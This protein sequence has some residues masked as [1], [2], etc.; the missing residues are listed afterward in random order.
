MQ[1]RNRR[2]YHLFLRHHIFEA[3]LS[4]E[5]RSK[6][7]VQITD[8]AYAVDVMPINKV[9]SLQTPICK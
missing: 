4:T 5:E 9:L 1:K 7:A 8:E 2:I 3:L 6:E